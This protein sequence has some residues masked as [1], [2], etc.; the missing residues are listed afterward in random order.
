MGLSLLEGLRKAGGAGFQAGLTSVMGQLRGGY[1]RLDQQLGGWLPGGGIANPASRPARQLLNAVPAAAQELGGIALTQGL[2]RANNTLARSVASELNRLNPQQA[3]QELNAARSVFNSRVEPRFRVGPMAP[4]GFEQ[5]PGMTLMR[6]GKTFSPQSIA[7]EMDDYLRQAKGY[8][9]DLRSGSPMFDPGGMV[10]TGPTKTAGKDVISTAERAPGWVAAHEMGHLYDMR[11]RNPD[12]G[13]VR[14]AIGRLDETVGPRSQTPIAQ[15]N[16]GLRASTPYIAGMAGSQDR[17]RSLLG[18]AVEG[19]LTGLALNA[20]TFRNELMADHY[21]RTIAREAG[22][23]W[24]EAANLA[25]KGTYVF[26]NAAPGAISG[27]AGELLSRGSDA[28]VDVIKGGIVDPAARAL[29]GGDNKVESQLRQYGYDPAQ[30]QLGG[31]RE[32]LTVEKRSPINRALN[33][34]WGQR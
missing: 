26:G 28:V 3:L 11:V 1:Q 21:G 6:D 22:I 13:F 16:T 34:L 14:N 25:A 33:G 30:Y 9:V 27:I 10:E 5:G 7:S 24:N 12:N 23:K 15:R 18:A 19:A 31:S 8:G 17:D 29:R 4:G 32:Q 2:S 20:G